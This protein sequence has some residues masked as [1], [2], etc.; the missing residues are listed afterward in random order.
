MS[1]IIKKIIVGGWVHGSGARRW[2]R[3]SPRVCV[4]GLLHRLGGYGGVGQ[5]TMVNRLWRLDYFSY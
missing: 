2:G 5:S 4:H 1:E 3:G